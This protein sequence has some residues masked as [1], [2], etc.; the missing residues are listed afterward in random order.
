[1]LK[2]NIIFQNKNLCGVQ[3]GKGICLQGVRNPKEISFISIHIW[4]AP[5]A[6]CTDLSIMLVCSVFH[7]PTQI[8]TQGYGKFGSGRNKM[9][10]LFQCKKAVDLQT[11]RKMQY[12]TILIIL[13]K[14]DYCHWCRCV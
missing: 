10:H 7:P 9:S 12:C 13:G 3:S 14:Q 8:Y 11:A 6:F 5:F 1:M 4:T 2:E